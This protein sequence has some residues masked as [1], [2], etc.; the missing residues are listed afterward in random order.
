MRALDADFRPR[1]A[2]QPSFDG[3]D[4]AVHAWLSGPQPSEESDD[5]TAETPGTEGDN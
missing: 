4:R 1:N 2:P 5:D 3:L